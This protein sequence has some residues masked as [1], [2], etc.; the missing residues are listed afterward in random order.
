MKFVANVAIQTA[1]PQACYINSSQDVIDKKS[2]MCRRVSEAD[3]THLGVD[4]TRS[5]L[6]DAIGHLRPPALSPPN[7][8]LPYQK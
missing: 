7:R 4:I 1:Q 2:S 6:F 8:N 3:E 5:S